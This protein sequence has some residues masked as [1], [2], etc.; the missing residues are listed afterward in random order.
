MSERFSFRWGIP[1]MDGGFTDVPN[2]FF[3][4]YSQLGMKPQE[5]MLILHLARYQW[6]RPGSMCHPSL[7]TVAREMGY[8]VR[9][10]RKLLAGLEKRGLITRELRPGNTSLYDFS[11]T[12]KTISEMASRQGEEPEDRTS[13]GTRSSTRNSGSSQPGTGGPGTPEPEGRQTTKEKHE[14]NNNT[15][16]AGELADE[17]RKAVDL[18][19]D[20]GVTATVAR[21]LAR[22]HSLD[23][24]CDW[25]RYVKAQKGLNNEAGLLIHGLRS[26]DEP[27]SKNPFAPVIV[28][29]PRDWT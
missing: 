22:E 8:G 4:H 21:Q 10:V 14:H 7:A 29:A 27:P 17:E 20:Y 13:A 26:G 25:K 12:A 18:L 2:V 23:R 3:D 15:V 28:I 16:V 9:Y 24:I 5:F 1:G 11:P 6:E 19:T